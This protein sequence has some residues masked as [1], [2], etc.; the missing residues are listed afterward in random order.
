MYYT[1]IVFLNSFRMID[2]FY[3]LL[4]AILLLSPLTTF[5]PHTNTL[6]QILFFFRGGGG[7]IHMY[8]HRCCCCMYKCGKLYIH[9]HRNVIWSLFFVCDCLVGCLL[10][11]F[12]LLHIATEILTCQLRK[13]EKGIC[14]FSVPCCYCCFAL[15]C[16]DFLVVLFMWIWLVCI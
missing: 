11:L 10:L 1:K 7:N 3:N 12:L 16:F 15:L 2:L 5:L 14:F 9:S 4:F 6:E 13:T 8:E